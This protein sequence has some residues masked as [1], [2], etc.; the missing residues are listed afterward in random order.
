MFIPILVLDGKL[1]LR[2]LYLAK[3]FDG[4]MLVTCAE[5]GGIVDECGRRSNVNW[6]Y[7]S[8]VAESFSLRIGGVD[9]AALGTS[10]SA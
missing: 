6:C 7:Y 1:Y 9:V 5:Y 4:G 8:G 2:R 10:Q 3:L